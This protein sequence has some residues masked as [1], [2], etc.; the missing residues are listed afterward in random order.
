MRM[1]IRRRTELAPYLFLLPNLVIFTLF[2]VIPTLANFYLGL[3]RT[4]PS[5]PPQFVG[6]ENFRY[7]FTVDDL[8]KRSLSNLASFMVFDVMAIVVLSVLI[9]VLLNQSI[10]GR[11]FYRSAFF[12][13][14]MLSPVVIALV[15]GWILNNR[16]GL[17]NA[18]VSRIGLDPQPWLLKPDL[19]RF[20][21]VAVHVWATVGFFAIIILAGLQSIPASL[22]EAAEVDGSTTLQNFFYITLPLLAPSIMTV[23]LLSM[24]RAFEIFDHV[25]ILTGGGPGTA[26]MMVIQYIYRAAFELDQQGRASAASL[27][28]FVILLVLALVQY[29]IGKQKEAL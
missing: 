6:L 10:R 21:V 14:V 3:F 12:F 25:Y 26:T 22:Y 16:F 24:I 23:S 29:R 13:P 28:L 7:I 4:S 19:A 15:W 20:W 17:L 18:M 8:F 1:G 11:G 27:V 5:A 2:I 9:G